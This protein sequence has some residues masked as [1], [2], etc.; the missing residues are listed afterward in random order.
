MEGQMLVRSCTDLSSRQLEVYYEREVV[1]YPASYVTLLYPSAMMSD[2]IATG[3]VPPMWVVPSS[4]R[5]SRLIEVVNVTAEGSSELAWADRPMHPEDTPAWQAAGRTMSREDRTILVQMADLGA[6]YYSR[7]NV[8]G[9][10][11]W[12]TA[13]EYP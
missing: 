7:W 5:E 3:D 6:Q 4:A 8:E 1:S 9:G 12:S 13:T 2:S 11:D 10:Y